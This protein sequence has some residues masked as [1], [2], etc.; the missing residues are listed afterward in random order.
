MPRDVAWAVIGATK[1]FDP[2]RGFAEL[3]NVVE[4]TDATL[5]RR[6]DRWWMYLLLASSER[7]AAW[8]LRGGRLPGVCPGLR[9]GPWHLDR[10]HLLRRRVRESVG[11]I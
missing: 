7:S 8:D 4:L 11:A 5:A 10:A 3:T 6:G 9:S 2:A 1:V